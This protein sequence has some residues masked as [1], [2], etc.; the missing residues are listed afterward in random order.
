MSLFDLSFE[1]IF[2]LVV[3]ALFVLGPER[4]PAAASWLAGTISGARAWATTTSEA[5]RNEVGPELDQIRQPLHELRAP[6]RELRTLGDPRAAVMR[7]LLDDAGTRTG[8]GSGAGSGEVSEP[9]VPSGAAAATGTPLD[10]VLPFDDE[11][12]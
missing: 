6:L 3:V 7:H 10:V 4:L 9:V 5:L 1:K 11:A 8:P 12:T 2:I